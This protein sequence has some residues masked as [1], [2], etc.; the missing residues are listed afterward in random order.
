VERKPS[1]KA[2]TVRSTKSAKNPPV[3]T[4]SGGGWMER[5]EKERSTQPSRTIQCEPCQ[6][7]AGWRVK[8]AKKAA[9]KV[10]VNATIKYY[11]QRVPYRAVAVRR[12]KNKTIFIFILIYF[13]SIKL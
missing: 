6:A 5:K 3:C 7:A 1:S 4:V 8:P 2:K 9:K 12:E 11:L 13:N 10:K